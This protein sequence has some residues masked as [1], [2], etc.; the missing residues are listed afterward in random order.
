VDLTATVGTE[1]N[2]D[3]SLD[4]NR[5]PGK[6]SSIMIG[7]VPTYIGGFDGVAQVRRAL[8]SAPGMLASCNTDDQ[9]VH[10]RHHFTQ[11]EHNDH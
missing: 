9:K 11:L 1:G 8:D 7:I 6:G 2:S 5:I 10:T 3:G 4:A